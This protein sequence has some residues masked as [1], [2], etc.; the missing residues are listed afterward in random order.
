[1]NARI[2]TY[3]QDRPTQFLKENPQERW[4]CDIFPQDGSD[5][6]GVGSTEPEAI[7]NAATAYLRWVKGDRS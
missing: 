4:R 7:L 3:H 2:T 6:H 1:M 5:H